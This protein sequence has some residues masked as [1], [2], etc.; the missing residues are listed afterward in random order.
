MP[1]LAYIVIADLFVV[2]GIIG[3][4]PWIVPTWSIVLF[5]L[6]WVTML[7]V[8]RSPS[9]SGYPSNRAIA[10]FGWGKVAGSNWRGFSMR[11]NLWGQGGW[12]EFGWEAVSGGVSYDILSQ[13][14]G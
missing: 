14:E 4:H 9:A 7:A 13:L 8:P 3:F 12:T 1:G 6:P 11:F 10:E 5:V 2:T